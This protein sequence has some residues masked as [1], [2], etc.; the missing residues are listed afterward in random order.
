M[1]REEKITDFGMHLAQGNQFYYQENFQ[2]AIEEYE[3]A[4]ENEEYITDI[5]SLAKTLYWRA[6]HP[7]RVLFAGATFDQS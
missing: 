3:L 4:L 7:I 5:P 1:N 6:L 2:E